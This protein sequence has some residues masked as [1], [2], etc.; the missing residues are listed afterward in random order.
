MQQF[1]GGEFVAVVSIPLQRQ[2][3]HTL[4]TRFVLSI[5]TIEDGFECANRLFERLV[6]L[7]D[8]LVEGVLIRNKLVVRLLAIV[9]YLML[10]DELL[11]EGSQRI[12]QRF[13]DV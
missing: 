11:L 3:V 6:V 13:V 10:L 8:H 2:L 9:S 5:V 12:E 1:F 4:D 7:A